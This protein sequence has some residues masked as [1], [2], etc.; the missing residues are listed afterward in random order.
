VSF[1][2]SRLRTA[3]TPSVFHFELFCCHSLFIL[4][5]TRGLV[6]CPPWSPSSLSFF[7]RGNFSSLLSLS[8]RLL[9]LPFMHEVHDDGSGERALALRVRSALGSLVLP[10]LMTLT[11]RRCPLVTEVPIFSLCERRAASR[12]FPHCLFF[13]RLENRAP[14]LRALFRSPL[15]SSDRA[16]TGVRVVGF[17]PGLHF[18]ETR[19]AF[20]FFPLARIFRLPP[21]HLREESDAL[22]LLSVGILAS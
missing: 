9:F 18:F 11:L 5:F 1:G 22:S 2:L 4:F 6:F 16:G 21:M 3:W 19:S 14:G 8:I 15:P 7:L 10:D 17:Y 12:R 20:S 13:L